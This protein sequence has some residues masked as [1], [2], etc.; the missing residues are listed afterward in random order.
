VN[1]V[2][3][4]VL[5]VLRKAVHDN[6]DWESEDKDARESCKTTYDL[7][8]KRPFGKG[9]RQQ[10]GMQIT[11]LESFLDLTKIVPINSCFV[12]LGRHSPIF[13]S[14]FYLFSIFSSNSEF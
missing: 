9:S 5:V 8:Q 4:P 2:C 12:T 13:L 10:I 11:L 6:G 14:S 7:A 3:F 1:P